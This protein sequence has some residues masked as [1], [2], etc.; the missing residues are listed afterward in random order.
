MNK[1]YM[2]LHHQYWPPLFTKEHRLLFN[3]PESKEDEKLP[4]ENV[5]E[6]SQKKLKYSEKKMSKILPGVFAAAG[7]GIV[8]YKTAQWNAEANRNAVD[9]QGIANQVEGQRQADARL[10]AILHSDSPVITEAIR[11]YM[12]SKGIDEQV[13][14]NPTNMTPV[15]KDK[16]RKIFEADL[17]TTLVELG[18]N[19]EWTKFFATGVLPGHLNWFESGLNAQ[20]QLDLKIV[21][22]REYATDLALHLPGDKIDH[23]SDPSTPDDYENR[24]KRLLARF[25]SVEPDGTG[26]PPLPNDIDNTDMQAIARLALAQTNKAA[27]DAESGATQEGIYNMLRDR[28]LSGVDVAAGEEEVHDIKHNLYYDFSEEAEEHNY[29]PADGVNVFAGDRFGD[30]KLKLAIQLGIVTDADLHKVNDQ[31]WAKKNEIADHSAKL[32]G[33]IAEAKNN[34]LASVPPE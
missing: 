19:D 28:Y 1:Y 3:T 12:I 27:Y 15:D 31:Y 18:T 24:D 8:G 16:V 22:I 23:D 7:I 30:S 6:S 20:Q 29:K 34:L 4:D 33:S 32:Q 17:S 26:T 25:V 2:K 5:Q 10:G 14:R 11:S 9:K 13:L 21:F